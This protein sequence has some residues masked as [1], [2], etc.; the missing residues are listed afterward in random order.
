MGATHLYRLP[1][2][3]RS[4]GRCRALTLAWTVS[5][6][7]NPILIINPRSDDVFVDRVHMLADSVDVPDELQEKLRDEYPSAVVRARDLE[8]E[9]RPVWYVY[10][11][12]RWVP[13]VTKGSDERPRA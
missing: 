13:P 3:R 1:A 4:H 12:G 2:S 11:E 8:G 5:G 7:A 9:R 6:G 10:R